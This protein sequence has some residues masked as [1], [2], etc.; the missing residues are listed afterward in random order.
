MSAK[1]S[2]YKVRTIFLFHNRKMS[3][4]SSYCESFKT[5]TNER[6]LNLAPGMYIGMQDMT[7]TSNE[8]EN[9]RESFLS[10]D[11][12]ERPVPLRPSPRK[13][14]GEYSSLYSQRTM[15]SIAS[16]EHQSQ[17]TVDVH[18]QWRRYK[19]HLWIKRGPLKVELWVSHLP[20]SVMVYSRH[21]WQL[22]KML[23]L[24]LLPRN[25]QITLTYLSF[26]YFT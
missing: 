18:L 10:S 16:H 19:C 9:I 12:Y 25:F 11:T 7:N 6:S 3:V 15:A 8:Y 14:P 24:L 4:Q 23:Q 5:E 22:S 13:P 21:S 17:V 26:L 1:L 20:D 2:K